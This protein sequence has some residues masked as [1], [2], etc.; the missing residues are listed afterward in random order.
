MLPP[1]TPARPVPVTLDAAA[2]ARINRLTTIARFVSGLAHEMNNALQV[3]GGLVELLADRADIPADAA[4]RIQKIGGQADRASAVIRQL[5]TFVREPGV[6]GGPI[7]LGPV[8]DRALALRKYQLGRA[9][10]AI[11]WARSSDAYCVI[12]SERALEQ[13]VVNLL[14]NAEEAIEGQA[15]RRV[16][17]ALARVAGLVRLSVS[18]SGHGVSPEL[19]GRIFDPFFTTR[20]SERAVGLGLT[21]AEAVAM[22]HGGCLVLA[23]AGPGTTTFALDLP[24]RA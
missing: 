19:R 3:M 8:V 21:V 17:L 15:E 18:D 10:I 14:V 4:V 9:G 2:L 22:S 5:L 11:E 6:E 1:H 24:E 20:T 13:V 12:G 23:D 16:S 7:D